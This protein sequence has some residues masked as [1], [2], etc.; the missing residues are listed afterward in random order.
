MPRVP[1]EERPLALPGAG[2][3]TALPAAQLPTGILPDSGLGRSVARLGGD[4]Q[5]ATNIL[6]E[7]HQKQKRLDRASFLI[8]AN[9]S[10]SD[11]K[12]AILS[13]EL[14]KTGSDA[15]GG[16][17]RVQ[18]GM[19]ALVAPF[20][21]QVKDDQETLNGLNAMFETVVQA[22]KNSAAT[23]ELAQMEKGLVDTRERS[24]ESHKKDAF[25][26]GRDGFDIDAINELILAQGAVLDAQELSPELIESEFKKATEEIYGASIMAL[27]QHHPETAVELEEQGAFDDFLSAKQLDTVKATA[28]T[29]QKAMATEL[30]AKQA[31][32]RRELQV[33]QDAVQDAM[34]V[35]LTEDTLTV[36]EVTASIITPEDK[37]TMLALIRTHA[38][39]S[40]KKQNAPFLTSNA[41]VYADQMDLALRGKSDRNTVI[42][43]IGNKDELGRSAGL[44]SDDAKNLLALSTNRNST[45]PKFR[46]RAEK[47]GAAIK[48]IESSIKKGNIL[49]GT[50]DPLSIQDAYN[51]R[52][53]FLSDL[54]AGEEEGKKL[55]DM[56]NPEHKDY[57]I[58][59][60][61]KKHRPELHQQMDRLKATFRKQSIDTSR[62]RLPGESI[63]DYQIRMQ[64]L[65]AK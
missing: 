49:L 9:S 50:Q 46:K 5:Q 40:L 25:I 4:L 58:S 32:E 28:K 13:D 64:K 22:G 6:V 47:I 26:I 17:Q 30:K 52:V 44:G 41:K 53:E 20:R 12:R 42:G 33:R 45:V 60:I 59:D 65:D 51:A 11:G 18:N 36:A 57:I 31:Q 54:Q 48:A 10:L 43:L 21:E 62:Q 14:A 61:I 23:H 16:T 8:E 38:D 34:L 55:E 3:S 35:K 39:A 56:L 29:A 19:D 27:F 2:V 37:R 1:I 63:S 7:V 24:L 15:R